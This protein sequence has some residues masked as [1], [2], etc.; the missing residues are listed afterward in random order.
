DRQEDIL[1]RLGLA[2]RR[3]GGRI[4]CTIPSYR[5][6]LRREVDLIEE[7]ARI[8]GYDDIPVLPEVRHPV[9][10]EQ[11]EVKLRRMV[12]DVLSAAGFDEAVTFSFI[13]QAEAELLG[14]D[15]TVAVD[16]LNRRT[17]NVLRP[18]L[19]PSL[20][21][22]CKTNQDAGTAEVSLYEIA[23]C[24]PAAEDGRLPAEHVELALVTTGEPGR[25]RGAVEAVVERLAPRGELAVRP[26]PAGHLAAGSAAAVLLDGRQ[27]GTIGLV[28]ERVR[29]YYGLERPAAAAALRF[30]DLLAA[31]ELVRTY[32]PL[33]KFPAVRR[34]LSVIVDE[35]V[36][37]QRLSDAIAAVAQPLRE[38]VEYVTTYRGRPIPPGRKSVT[39]T[40][41][42]RCGDRT[43]RGEEVDRQVDEVVSAL[44]EALGAELRR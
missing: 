30:E 38:A 17:N 23:N 41:V 29:D 27:I 10:P 2:P 7:V 9:V 25:L 15:R 42:Y 19:L 24:F 44:R 34:D 35:A 6:D 40:L 3:D 36:N 37:W 20:L 1:R 21:R 4:V 5:A 11:R 16:K 39:V 43:L 18:T 22:A 33:P 8:A 14:I 12:A 31:A 28:A 26:G 32:R 13:D